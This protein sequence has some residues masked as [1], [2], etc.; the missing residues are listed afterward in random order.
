[1]G[2]RVGRLE[3]GAGVVLLWTWMVSVQVERIGEWKGKS[4]W[5][6]QC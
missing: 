3:R 4:V 5:R 6:S 1:M 2:I